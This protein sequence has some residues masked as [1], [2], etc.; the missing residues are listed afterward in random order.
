M[1]NHPGPSFRDLAE[2]TRGDQNVQRNFR[3]WLRRQ[4]WMRCLPDPVV[5]LGKEL[6]AIYVISIAFA[7]PRIQV[8]QDLQLQSTLNNFSLFEAAIYQI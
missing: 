6:D 7:K 4:P 3:A 2:C 5:N 8:N 1:R